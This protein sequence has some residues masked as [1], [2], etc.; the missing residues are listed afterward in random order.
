VLNIWKEGKTLSG[1]RNATSSPVTRRLGAH[2]EG[3]HILMNSAE[4]KSLGLTVVSSGKALVVCESIGFFHIC[5]WRVI[6]FGLCYRVN[7]LR[8]IGF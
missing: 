7:V 2:A 4:V 6:C 3:W 1:F 8:N 5:L